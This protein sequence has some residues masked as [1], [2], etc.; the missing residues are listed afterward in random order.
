MWPGP[1]PIRWIL[2]LWKA[3]AANCRVARSVIILL[4][5]ELKLRPPK[6]LLQSTYQARLVSLMVSSSLCYTTSLVP[7]VAAAVSRTSVR[8]QGDTVL[9]AFSD[10]SGLYHGLWSLVEVDNAF[11]LLLMTLQPCMHAPPLPGV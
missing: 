7:S 9:A 2:L 3:L 6:T 5:T 8:S 10:R 11:H 1:C 4:Y